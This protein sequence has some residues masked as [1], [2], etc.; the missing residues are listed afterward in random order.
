MTEN[1]INKVHG[2]E[3][4]PNEATERGESSE[5]NVIQAMERYREP[6]FP[7][8]SNRQERILVQ[9]KM[10]AELD[11]GF[12]Y[13]QKAL[14]MALETRLHSIREACNHV[15]VTGKTHLRQNRL[16]YFGDVLMQVGKPDE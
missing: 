13:R 14:A 9:K 6:S 16:E 4:L 3:S 15:L 7:F 1:T 11:Q 12:E 5:K 10:V 8:V 2:I